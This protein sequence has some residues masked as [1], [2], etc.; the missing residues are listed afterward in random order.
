MTASRH[1]YYFFSFSFARVITQNARKPNLIKLVLFEVDKT[2]ITRNMMRSIIQD[3]RQLVFSP[4]VISE[5]VVV[6]NEEGGT[7]CGQ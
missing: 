4:R 5:E 3:V 6:V 2:I 7:C 1:F